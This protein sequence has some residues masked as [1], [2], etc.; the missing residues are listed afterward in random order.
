M[1]VSQLSDYFDKLYPYALAEEWDNVGL[2]VGD[3]KAAVT[4][5]MMAVD[6]SLDVLKEAKDAG[7]NVIVTHHPLIFRAIKRIHTRDAQ[8]ELIAFALKNDISVIALHTNLDSAR[9]GLNDTLCDLLTLTKTRPLV[10][11]GRER[12]YKLSVTVPVDAA[13]KVRAA[14]NEAGAGQIGNYDHCSFSVEGE[15]TCRGDERSNPA[16]GKQGVLERLKERRIEVILRREISG[17]VIEAMKQAHPYEEVAYDLYVLHNKEL[18]TGLARIGSLAKAESLDAFV[19]RVQKLGIM[20]T[21][22]LGDGKREV[23]KVALCSGAGA[24]FVGNACAGGADVYLTAEIKHHHGAMAR[25]A[26]MAIVETE[27]YSLERGHWPR[28]KELLQIE[29]KDIKVK[30]SERESILWRRPERG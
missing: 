27:H 23:K 7:C 25:H 17:R 28:L 21:R 4:G 15:G 24:D 20:V 14:M 29:F 6:V 11:S 10:D 22:V 30:I 26:D 19:T 1:K 8:G 9:G 2:V 13:E 18:G 3:P 5:V 12:L 16:I